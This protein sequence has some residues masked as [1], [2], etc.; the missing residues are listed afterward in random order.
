VTVA[1][2]RKL[3]VIL[4]GDSSSLDKALGS[5]HRTVD[6]F[7]SKLASFGKVAAVGL[8]AAGVGAVAMGKS[9][10]DAAI[11]SQKV[12][13]QTEAVIKSMGG[14]SKVTASQVADLSTQLSLKTGIDD[15]LIQ[16]GSNVL[17]TFGNVRN[18]IGAGNDIF[19][20]AN[21]AALD[22][23][24]ALGTDMSAAA[25]TV[26][27]ALNDPVDG[28][29][30]LQRSGI[31]F[32]DQQKEQIKAMAEVGDVAGAQK[33]MLAELERQFGGSAE[34]QATAT[35]K[36]KVAWGNIQ[37]QLGAKLLPVVETVATWLSEKLPS[38]IDTLGGIV[39]PVFKTI[40]DAFTALKNAFQ[41]GDSFGFDGSDGL[42]GKVMVFGATAREVFDQVVEGFKVF[43]N[44]FKAGDTF[45]LGG[46]D[47][48]V[49]MFAI[50][51]D[52][53]RKVWDVLVPAVGSF[54]DLM[55]NN[56]GPVMAVVVTA[57]GAWALSA[58]AAAASTIAAA[59]P[60]IAIAAAIA[61][62]AAGIVY[63][64]QHFD[65]F[66][67][68]VD[69]VVAFVRDVAAPAIADFASMVATKFGELVGWVQ[70]HWAAIQ[71]AIGH[72][73]TVI[74]EVIS[75]AIGF[76]T[77]VWRA[78][79][80]DL[81]N[82]VGIAWGFIRSTVENAINLVR[83]VIETVVALINGD[84]GAAWE[85][86]K[87][88]FSAV[89]DQIVNV[90]TTAIGLVQS[91]L[92]AAVSSLQTAWSAVWSAFTSAVSSAWDG[93]KGFVS[94]GI[95]AVVGIVQSL[96]GR[97][98]S[99]AAGAFDGIKNAFKSAINWIIRGWNGLEFKIPG[100]DPPGP[101]PTFGGF[102]LGLPNVPLLAAGGIVNRP[103]LAVVGEAGPEAVIPLN[104]RHGIGGM[105]VSITIPG[106]GDPQAVAAEV[107]RE[108]LRLGRRNGTVFGDVA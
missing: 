11:E 76:I 7:G 59:A 102:T 68:V 15:E 63:A 74:Q 26:G 18:E 80:D 77:E 13:A 55:R 88:I 66:R 62:V 48:I 47:G 65:G 8:A 24:V 81:L 106:A 30:K 33:I 43:V 89:W 36:L 35:D 39:G 6:G 100:F 99:L 78:W 2:D 14:A 29:S 52:T 34:A 3:T 9:F 57:F 91:I 27:K 60:F 75:V 104:G 96:P 73:V 46:S 20:R 83:S 108:L 41:A 84:W 87:G 12:T 56:L 10:V 64:Y 86:I 42:I 19:N 61:A 67:A 23:S 72:V 97:I 53:A 31:Q 51:G 90:V 107:R 25:M 22:M 103:T 45:G 37:E 44:A 16:S 21:K 28:L 94:G 58:A 95:D 70:A 79:G 49:G 4:S 32:T 93:I 54:I 85:G 98:S 71:E 38:A 105:Q 82:I 69:G 1:G 17:L 40:V 101:G 50:L 92:G 5:A